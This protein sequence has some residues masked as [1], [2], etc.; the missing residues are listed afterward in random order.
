MSDM[1]QRIVDVLNKELNVSR[2]FRDDQLGRVALL[3]LSSMREPTDA[4]LVAGY[5]ALF[6]PFLDEPDMV[7]GWAA[8]IDAAQK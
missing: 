5:E 7:A 6:V 8:M 3:I 2:H 4:M 1:L